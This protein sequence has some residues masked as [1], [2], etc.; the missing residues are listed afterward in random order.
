[1]KHLAVITICLV[2]TSSDLAVCGE[3]AEKEIPS[4]RNDVMAVLSKAGCNAGACHGNQNGKG[5]FKLSLRGQDPD[6]DFRSIVKQHGGRRVNRLE[7]GA[8]L[9]LRKPTSQVAHQGGKRFPIGSELYEILRGW[10]AAGTPGPDRTTA[11]LVDLQ[12]TP[13]HQVLAAPNQQVQI[14]AVATFSDGT[15]RNVTDLAC[16]ETS[17][18]VVAVDPSGMVHRQSFGETTILVRFLNRQ[19]PVHLAFIPARPNFQW[20][21]PPVRNYID[22]HIY[23]KLKSLRMNPSELADDNTFVRRAYLD[24]IGVLPTMDEAKSFVADP[25]PDKRQQ[26]IDRLLQRAEFADHWALKWSD[27]LK[28][29]EKTLDVNGVKAFYDWIRESM[30][31]GKP[32][33]QFV[34]ELVAARG[35]TYK[36][37]PAN[38]YRANRDPLTRAETTARLFLGTRLQC[39]KC[40]NH[41]FE[42]WTQDDYYSWAALFARVDYK[43]VENKRK[44]KFDKNEFVGEQIVLVKNEGEVENPSSGQD[45]S[46]RFLGGPALKLDAKADRLQP[47]ANW[48]A[49]PGNELFAKT[50]A[51]LVWYHLMGRGLVEPIDDFRATNPAVNPALLEA[52]A[53]D[54]AESKFDLRHLVRVIMNSRTY[55]LS[56][57]PNATNAED[58]SNFSRAVVRRLTAEQLLDAQTQLLDA[59]AEFAGYDVGLR[60]GQIPG[61]RKLRRRNTSPTSDDRFLQTFGKPERLL[62]CECERSN[63]TTLTHAFVLVSGEGINRRLAAAGNRLDRMAKSKRDDNNVITD[64]YWCALS[65]P[66]TK[67]E[68]H[69]MAQHLANAKGRFAALQDVAWAL[70]NSKEFIFRR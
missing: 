59:P 33:D 55:Q 4:F 44:D 17:D 70:L 2:L 26:L 29:E 20:S 6:F 11:Q 22:K 54:F 32:I 65:R 46:P 9:L 57:V 51:N 41:P 36:S 23:A 19:L 62:A 10:I 53:R 24:A 43:I 64:L 12:V 42:R 13:R 14:K 40:H 63:E 28:N 69:Q 15:Q 52:L 56:S 48:L 67:T 31:E 45:A 27:L 5:G 66:P 49:N 34:R 61:V 35:S 7:P 58:Q 21:N 60:A 39:A 8:S 47:L 38:Y 25:A 18:S 30:A 68:L 1:M 16:Y 50:Q 37:P 3:V